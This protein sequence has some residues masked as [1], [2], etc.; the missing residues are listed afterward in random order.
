M[1][2]LEECSATRWLPYKIEKNKFAVACKTST[3]RL[4]STLL[5]IVKSVCRASRFELLMEAKSCEQVRAPDGGK[6]GDTEGLVERYLP[7]EALGV[8]SFASIRDGRFAQVSKT[9]HG[10]CTQ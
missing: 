4:A 10:A 6:R 8:A 7:D 3:W 1:S 9:V 5:I 2:R